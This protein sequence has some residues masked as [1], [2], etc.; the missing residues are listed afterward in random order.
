MQNAKV[1]G[2]RRLF[3]TI[4]NPLK[5]IFGEIGLKSKFKRYFSHAQ[6]KFCPLTFT[7]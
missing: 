1:K 5:L 7:L 4:K 2:Q 3:S 6:N